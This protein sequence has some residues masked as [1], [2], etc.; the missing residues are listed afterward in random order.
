MIEAR[1]IAVIVAYHPDVATVGN[2][3]S[4]LQGQTYRVILVDNGSSN[5]FK[6]W[7]ADRDQDAIDT[8]FLGENRGIAA[9]QNVGIE[10]AR[11]YRPSHILLLDQDSLPATD[12]VELLLD[13]TQ[14]MASQGHKVAAVG[15]RYLDSRQQNPPPFIQLRG[16]Q[17]RRQP[18]SVPGAIVPVDYLIASG[19]LIP[20]ASLNEV[21]PMLESLFIDYVD[22]EWGLRA[23]EEGFQSFG[24]CAAHMRHDLGDKPIEFA[25]KAFLVHSPLRHYYMFRNAVWLYRQPSLPLSWKL[26]DGWRLLLKYVFYSVF[27]KPRPQHLRMMT[28]GIWHALSNRLGRFGPS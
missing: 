25:G 13:A 2:L 12:M 1:V 14:Q 22:I 11:Q 10:R 3:L 15:P 21:G 28:L 7:L 24:V 4:I 20:I 26:A 5:S 9:A 6:S 17:V 18:C 27:T 19:S 8:I 16:L 23:K